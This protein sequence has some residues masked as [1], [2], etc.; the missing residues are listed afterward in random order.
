M[1]HYRMVSERYATMWFHM[2]QYG[3]K[4]YYTVGRDSL[5]EREHFRIGGEIGPCVEDI[6]VYT[7]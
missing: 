7:S 1:V 4:W 6:G 2:I 3:A 5:D